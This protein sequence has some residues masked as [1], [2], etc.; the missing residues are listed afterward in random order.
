LALDQETVQRCSSLRSWRAPIWILREL[1]ALT[2][3]DIPVSRNG[4]LSSFLWSVPYVVQSVSGMLNVQVLCNL[5]WGM[6]I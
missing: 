2:A 6:C 4:S 3:L 5:I 1:D